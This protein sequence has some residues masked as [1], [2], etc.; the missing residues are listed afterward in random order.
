MLLLLWGVVVAA[1]LWCPA[2]TMV[3]DMRLSLSQCRTVSA[4]LSRVGEEERVYIHSSLTS[5]HWALKLLPPLVTSHVNAN[6]SHRPAL[7]RMMDSVTTAISKLAGIPC[8]PGLQRSSIP[9]SAYCGK[10]HRTSLPNITRSGHLWTPAGC[11]IKIHQ[12]ILDLHVL[13]I[14]YKYKI[15]LFIEVLI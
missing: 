3:M 8:C 6:S 12:N 7:T 15:N 5:W 4:V 14:N 2:V 10:D 11:L 1:E 13:L 9:K